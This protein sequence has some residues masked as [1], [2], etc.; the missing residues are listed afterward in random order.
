M[1]NEAT[2]REILLPSSDN[3]NDYVTNVYRKSADLDR[4]N[5]TCRTGS[6]EDL[7]HDYIK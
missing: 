6:K 1:F 5:R 4:N 7:Q 2:L 3:I